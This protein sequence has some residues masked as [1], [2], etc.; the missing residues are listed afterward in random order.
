MPTM[1]GGKPGGGGGGGGGGGSS[2]GGMGG[3]DDKFAVRHVTSER[4]APNG[5]TT[6]M[7]FLEEGLPAWGCHRRCPPPL[8]LTCRGVEALLAWG[9]HRPYP[10]YTGDSTT[11]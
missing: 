3:W 7:C 11:R 8:P 6:Y 10:L 4:Q 2:G 9:Y 1:L 5:R